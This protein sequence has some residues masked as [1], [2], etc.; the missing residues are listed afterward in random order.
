M[1]MIA[2]GFNGIYDLFNAHLERKDRKN[3]KSYF[4]IIAIH[5]N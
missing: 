4:L 3:L 5:V 2:A 1:G